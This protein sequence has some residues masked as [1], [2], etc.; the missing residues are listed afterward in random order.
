MIRT[1]TRSGKALIIVGVVA[2]LGGVL[3]GL[4]AAPRLAKHKP[5][6]HTAHKAKDTDKSSAAV[7]SDATEHS[8]IVPLGDFL[9]NLDAGSGVRYLRAEVAMAV[10]GLPEPKKRGH[11]GGKGPSLP[12]ADITLA[13]DRVIAV[14]SAG[15]FTSLR[16]AAG[17]S[18]L[19]AR[20]LDK[21]SEALPQ[22]E[23][24]EVLFTSF[25]MQ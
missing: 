13:R 22:Y 16:T 21:L 1:S 7:E 19:K 12:E 10:K 11:G 4:L 14:L 5:T 25:V 9:V 15:D 2:A 17:K 3:G 6:R 24:S 8:T 18:K 23:I 20:V